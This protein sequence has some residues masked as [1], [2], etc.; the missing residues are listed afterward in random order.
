MKCHNVKFEKGVPKR[1]E[2]NAASTEGGKEAGGD[3][4]GTVNVYMDDGSGGEKMFG[5]YDTVLLAIGRTGDAGKI[6]CENAGVEI[7]PRNGKIMTNERD[8]TNVSNIYA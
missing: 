8:Q 5:E 1:F 6:A 7:L 3:G 4:K 2:R